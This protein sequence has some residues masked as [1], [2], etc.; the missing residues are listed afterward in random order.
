MISRFLSKLSVNLSTEFFWESICTWQSTA[1][2]LYSV[3]GKQT[4]LVLTNTVHYSAL[5]L[6]GFLVDTIEEVGSYIQKRSSPAAATIHHRLYDEHADLHDPLCSIK[7][8]WH[9]SAQKGPGIYR[10]VSRQNEALWRVPIGDLWRW[11]RN[12]DGY[13]VSIRPPS[14]LGAYIFEQALGYSRICISVRHQ[15]A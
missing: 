11:S 1:L 10:H 9:R 6:R 15:R 2:T 13:R 4:I 5:G 14:E 3:W 7:L 8:L 12:E